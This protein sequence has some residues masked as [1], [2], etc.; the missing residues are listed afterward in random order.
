MATNLSIDPALIGGMIVRIGSKM[1][2]S[3][4]STKLQKLRLSMKGIG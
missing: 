4:L 1:V 2:D 3:S